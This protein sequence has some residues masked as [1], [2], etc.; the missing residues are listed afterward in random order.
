MVRY[1]KKENMKIFIVGIGSIGSSIASQLTKDGCEVTVIDR[2]PS[3][4]DDLANSIDAIGYQGNGASYNT[5]SELNAQDADVL[6]AVTDSDEVNIL[7][8]FTA[9]T[10]GTKHTIA[11]IRDIDY[12]GQNHFYKNQF[13]LSMIINPDLASAMEIFRTLRF[14][15]ATRIELFAGG[16][17]EVVE[18]TVREESPLVGRSLMDIRQNM[19]IN[20]LVC[21]TVRDGVPSVPKGNFIIQGGDVI[22]LTGDAAEFKN[23]FKKLKMPIKPLKSVMI[24]GDDRITFYLA[25]MLA[26][27]GV[28]VTIVDRDPVVCKDF[29]EKLPKVSVMNEDCLSYFDSMSE[30]DIN[31]TDAFIAISTNDEYNLIAAMYAESHGIS[32]VVSKI[33]AKSRRMVLPDDSNITI[34]SREDVAADRILGYTRALLNADEKDAVESLYILL[35]GQL[36]FIEF[37]VKSSDKYLNTKLKQLRMKKNILLAGI[38]RD[39]KMIIPMG[40]D[41]LEAGDV[42]L[43][44]AVGQ[45]I[46][47]LEDLYE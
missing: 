43:V 24:A 2:L 45:Q 40:D 1:M 17:A 4:L 26:K 14:P 23:S 41:H 13:G 46:A 27:H 36:E 47:R 6:I 42:A 19:G 22:Y 8:C 25:G 3:K 18:L 37:N 30:A 20:L 35:D 33:S 10:L 32:K 16:R 21:A 39:S 7:S 5:L 38:I 29:A 44:A 12:A 34:I 28:K 11:R 31:N 15:L 9:H